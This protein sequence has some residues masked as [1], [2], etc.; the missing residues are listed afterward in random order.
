MPTYSYKCTDCGH[1]FERFQSITAGPI[2]KCPNCGKLQARRLLGTGSGILFKGSGFY[3]TDY[4]SSTYRKSAEGDKGPSTK[5]DKD[6]P[7]TAS[8]STTSTTPAA[9]TPPKSLKKSA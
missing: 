5:K 3:Q 1:D 2:R 9:D 4:R 6:S 8:T 7:S